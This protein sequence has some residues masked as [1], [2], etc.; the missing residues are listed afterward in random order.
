MKR[1][2]IPELDAGWWRKNQ[3][4]G[5]NHAKELEKALTDY[6]QA[7]AGLE[8]T[9]C[10]DDHLA[11]MG[12][13]G[14]IEAAAKKVQD[15]AQKALKNPPKGKFDAEDFDH[16]VEALKKVGKAV[17]TARKD[18]A[19]LRKA[20][21]VPPAADEEA[22]VGL[23]AN[24]DKYQE[25]LRSM[26]RKAKDGPLAFA[27]GAGAKPGAHRMVL[28]RST[29]GP[30]LAARLRN[31]AGLKKISAG[32]A[33]AHRQ[34]PNVL[35]L[36]VEGPVIGGLKAK[37]LQLFKT[38]KPQPFDRV[39]LLVDGNEVE[40]V[41][42]PADREADESEPAQAQ[43]AEGTSPP[44]P[45]SPPASQSRATVAPAP[46][47]PST[48][49][50]APTAPAPVAPAP[51]QRTVDELN[52]ALQ[53]LTPAIRLA[54][55]NPQAKAEVVRLLEAVK[56]NL[57]LRRLP[58]AQRALAALQELLDGGAGRM[59]NPVA[60]GTARLAWEQARK[61]VRGELE[62]LEQ[63]IVEASRAETDFDRISAG[64]TGLYD[65][66][67]DLDERLLVELDGALSA[68]NEP[69]RLRF[70]ERARRV[71]G[72]YRAFV[73][74]DELVNSLDDNGFRPVKVRQT[75]GTVLD[76]I[77]RALG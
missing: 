19:S 32:V 16:T 42:D 1:N 77:A 6:E 12:S 11:C 55:A 60:Y 37:C 2:A 21:P 28:H 61:L 67:D 64:C 9:G 71:L 18:A 48:S 47:T 8:K 13:L 29:G 17:E 50:S 68:R 44:A 75:L 52:A 31:D 62:R 36:A 51:A 40:D 53:K 35:V 58:E 76:G 23:L 66:L 30:T 45:P 27:F 43:H 38:F 74:S 15:E 69:Q 65:L 59:Q 25:Y 7:R 39:M 10:D 54:L 46:A 24:P 5:L 41:P 4:E 72:E 34:H 22:G 63:A 14:R 49:A 20:L 33:G 70:H 56:S 26:L 57:D 3:P 73:A